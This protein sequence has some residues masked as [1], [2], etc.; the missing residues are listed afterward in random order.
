M[1]PAIEP[2]P[3]P[4]L[5]D[6]KQTIRY[7]RAPDGSSIAWSTLG[8][9]PPLVVCHA[10]NHLEEEL[11]SSVR[12]PWVQALARRHTL[13]RYDGRGSGLSDRSFT[14][15]SLES[16][17]ADLEAVVAA[18]GIQRFDLFTLILG[19]PVAIAYAARHPERVGRLAIVGGF[20]RGLMRRN[21]TP[22]EVARREARLALISAGWNDPDPIYRLAAPAQQVTQMSQREMTDY[23]RLL[24][25][26]CSG[27]ILVR[28]TRYQGDADVSDLAAQVRCPVLV[29]HS[30]H[31]GR[32]PFEEGLRLASLFPDATLVPLDSH[33]SFPTAGEPAFQVAAA[34]LD[35]F[36]RPAAPAAGPG[37][38]FPD[39]TPRERDV[40]QLIAQGL[41]NLQIAAH[42]G[43]SEKTVRN[44]VTPIFDKLGVENRSQA[45]VRA[46]EAGLGVARP[47]S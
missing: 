46:R 45:I 44:H 37:R 6:L 27:D 32:V 20:S 11:A 24:R 21:P 35:D 5:A 16:G 22:E 8:K 17:V 15:V 12:R 14:D 36:L 26:M 43:L 4:R 42:L 29:M 33:N 47:A 25:A 18:A 7:C 30:R 23:D 34:A 41:D 13:V 1:I 19:S 2:S 9:G 31:D 28:F 3:G 38:R 10:L 40:L 39:L